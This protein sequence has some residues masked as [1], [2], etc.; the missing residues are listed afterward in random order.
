MKR[1]RRKKR[2]EGKKE[3]KEKVSVSKKQNV[4]SK[5]KIK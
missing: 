4:I 2:K 5:I 1:K 3:K